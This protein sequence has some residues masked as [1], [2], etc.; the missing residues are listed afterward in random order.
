MLEAIDIACVR[1]SR[2]LFR[3]LSFRVV[4]GSALRIRGPNGAGKTSLLRILSGLSP[5]DEG[6]IS[7]NG[8]ALD[9]FG[10]D[11]AKQLLYVGHSN[12]LKGHL[13]ALE[14]LRLGLAIQGIEVSDDQAAAALA[15]EGLDTAADIPVQWLSAGQK[16]RVALTRLMFC[17]E[18]PLWILDEPFSALDEGAISRLSERIVQHLDSGGVVV[19]TTHQDIEIDAAV[20]TLELK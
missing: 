4:T 11:Y 19:Y 17:G 12:A 16:R 8:Q 2:D 6:R 14:N 20:H 5:L 10:D 9:K 15:T 13:S 7:W 1:G 3:Q 18:R